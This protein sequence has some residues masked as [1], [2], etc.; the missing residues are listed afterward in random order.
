MC[1]TNRT[2]KI[3]ERKRGV[4][5]HREASFWGSSGPW[6]ASPGL[7]YLPL[8]RWR[9]TGLQRQLAMIRC[10]AKNRSSITP[11]LG[12]FFAIFAVLQRVVQG[13][14][15]D[16]KTCSKCIK[17]VCKF[18]RKTCVANRRCKLAL[19]IDQCTTTFTSHALFTSTWLTL[20]SA[21]IR[22]RNLNFEEH[23]NTL[24]KVDTFGTF[25]P[26]LFIPIRSLVGGAQQISSTRKIPMCVGIMC[27]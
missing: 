20:N 11:R 5:R 27:V 12:R 9:Y 22:T 4:A 17:H 8:L 26:P 1:L 6:H 15:S 14:K 3:A 25:R 21:C 19:N 10:C 18:V 24:Y 23:Y 16:S 13:F 2:E 7:N